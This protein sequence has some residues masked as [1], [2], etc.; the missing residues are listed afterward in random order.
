MHRNYEIWPTDPRNELRAL[1]VN[2][3]DLG[4]ELKFISD[5]LIG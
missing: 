1:A 5:I 4:V 3:K 2:M